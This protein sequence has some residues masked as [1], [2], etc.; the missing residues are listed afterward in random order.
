M[1]FDLVRLR[2]L[3]GADAARFDVEALDECGSTSDELSAR[4]ARGAPSGA[5]VVAD[6]QLAGR[7][8][9]GR[10]WRSWREAPEKNLTFSLLWRFPLQAGGAGR[11]SGLSLAV[12]VAVARALESL[13]VPG[14]ALKWPNDILL[15]TAGSYGKLG[16]ILVELSTSRHM[17]EAIIGIGLNL[18]LPPEAAQTPEKDEKG[19]EDDNTAFSLA[20]AALS[21]ALPG[22]DRHELL[23][24]LLAELLRSLES[25]SS[26]GF[27]VLREEWMRRHAWQDRPVAL[28]GVRGEV[29]NAG[30]CLGVDEGGFLLIESDSGVERILSGDVSLRPV[31]ET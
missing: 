4:A 9:R 26:A 14:V 12:G 6:R 18:D 31:D 19:R 21:A 2:D 3:L 29:L 10:N 28:F 8:R 20:P 7:G 5:V 13:G 22:I 23:A 1:T 27:S 15:T 11:L 30:R 17:V 24:R 16:G 25:F